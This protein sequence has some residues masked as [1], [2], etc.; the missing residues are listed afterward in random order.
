M[1]PIYK[2]NGNVH[3]AGVTNVVAMEAIDLMLDVRAL[4]PRHGRSSGD[5]ADVRRAET[6]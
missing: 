3:V 6:S 5:A 1:E 4:I 2:K